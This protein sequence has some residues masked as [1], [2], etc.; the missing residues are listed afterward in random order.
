M[1]THRSMRDAAAAPAP[2]PD[3]PATGANPPA[4]T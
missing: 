1:K 4:G 3:A 2:A